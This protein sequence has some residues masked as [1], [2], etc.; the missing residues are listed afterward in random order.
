[1]RTWQRFR[2]LNAADRRLIVEGAAWLVFV[3]IG[4]SVLPFLTLRRVLSRAGAIRPAPGDRSPVPA[5]RVAWAV[6]SAARHLPFATTCLIESLAAQAM[7]R[8]RGVQCEVRVGVRP[9]QGRPALAAHAWVEHDGAVLLGQIDDLSE[10]AA[11]L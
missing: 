1:M 5:Q 6:T 10:Y 2:A 9:R 7:L 11:L 3:R 4:L 8:R